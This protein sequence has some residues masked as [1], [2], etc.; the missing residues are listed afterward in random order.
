M[1]LT[2]PTTFLSS[3]LVHFS[4]D[5]FPFMDKNAHFLPILVSGFMHI[6]R[7]HDRKRVRNALKFNS[8][9]WSDSCLRAM[10][11]QVCGRKPGGADG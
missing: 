9:L 10:D 1:G 4:R 7:D 2:F 5:T 8:P 11:L 3:I 6:L